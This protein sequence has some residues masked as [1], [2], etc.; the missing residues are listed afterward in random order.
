MAD[1]DRAAEQVGTTGSMIANVMGQGAIKPGPTKNLMNEV[2]DTDDRGAF[3]QWFQ[4]EGTQVMLGG[5]F[6]AIG[7]LGAGLAGIPPGGRDTSSLAIGAQ[8]ATQGWNIAQKQWDNRQFGKFIDGKIAEEMKKPESKRDQEK[9]MTLHQMKRNP[10]DFIKGVAGEGNWKERLD[11][12]FGLSEETYARKLARAVEEGVNYYATIPKAT[13]DLL[14]ARDPKGIMAMKAD[15]TFQ[16]YLPVLLQ[17]GGPLYGGDWLPPETEEEKEFM[18][19]YFGWTGL[20]KDKPETDVGTSRTGGSVVTPGATPAAPLSPKAASYQQFAPEVAPLP[21]GIVD[22][23]SWGPHQ[24]MRENH[25]AKVAGR[26]LSGWV[27]TQWNESAARV[28]EDRA[29]RK[30]YLKKHPLEAGPQDM[31][32][33]Y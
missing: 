13:R 27:G 23:D 6:N 18:K 12:R 25:P 24:G 32:M 1:Y 33:G 22:I 19:K 10:Q 11:Y 20:V 28:Q 7:S 30:K 26:A 14:D 29:R 2:A 21:P 5:M 15:L 4:S 3:A 8:N 16:E 9:L 31:L 17:P